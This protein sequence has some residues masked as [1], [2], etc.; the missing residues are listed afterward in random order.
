MT[1]NNTQKLFFLNNERRHNT[2][3]K[4]DEAL[5][6]HFQCSWTLPKFSVIRFDYSL[7]YLHFSEKYKFLVA[8][9]LTANP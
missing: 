6:V 9:P 7:K 2:L 8:D 1:T 4:R 5:W 3:F